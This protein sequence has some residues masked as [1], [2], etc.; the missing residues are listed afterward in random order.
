VDDLEALKALER[1]LAEQ[2][3][4]VREH[5]ELRLTPKAI[6]RIGAA[7]LARIFRTL[8]TIKG[9]CSF[10]GFPRLEAVAHA[11]EN[12]LGR[13]REGQ[14]ALSPALTNLL[15]GMV[16]AIRS[17]LASIESTGTDGESD[18]QALIDS[19]L[20]ADDP[21]PR[22]AAPPRPGPA[23]VP[24]EMMRA[25]GMKLLARTPEPQ[26]AHAVIADPERHT[27]MDESGAVRSIQAAN[28]DMPEPE[29]DAIWSPMHLER[30]ARTYWK[31]LSRVTLGLIRVRYTERERSVVL[32]ARPL[33]LLRFHAP[34]YSLSAR[35]GIVRWRIK[36]GLLVGRRD[37]GFLEIDVRRSSAPRPGYGRAH[38]EVE[39]A[40]FYPAIA[41]WLT[42]WFYRQTQSRIHVMVT[43]GFL[44]SL[45]KLELEVSAV[46][47]FANVGPAAVRRYARAAALRPAAVL[48][49]QLSGDGRR[50]PEQRP[51]APAER[52]LPAKARNT[53]WLVLG[54]LVA[55]AL[56]LALAA[57][58]RARR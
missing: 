33:T 12:L 32:I 11:G 5:G 44:R 29:L 53:P 6:R 19:L 57:A 25:S 9:S 34:E 54:G 45:A 50:S 16:D 52:R 8:H 18:H 31:Y 4:L 41:T 42:R 22:A 30:L 20:S 39:V 49:P 43:H 36:D 48:A 10:L 46:G 40:N 26:I 21:P 38:V 56:A 1:E 58:L 55:V 15:L 28:V 24:G 27:V 13:L 37:E 14:L 47:R 23:R 17:M 7:A 35:R 3:W 2:G 51:P